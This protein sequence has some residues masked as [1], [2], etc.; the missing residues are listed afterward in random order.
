MKTKRNKL[1]NIFKTSSIL[2][3]ALLLFWNCENDDSSQV[4]EDLTNSYL[5]YVSLEKT[6]YNLI[7]FFSQGESIANK[8]NNTDLISWAKKNKY[9]F[10]PNNFIKTIDSIG[11]QAYTTSLYIN[12]TPDNVFYNLVIPKKVA[13]SFISSPFIIKYELAEGTKQNY[14]VS[15]QN[16]FV[17]TISVFSLANFKNPDIRA[18]GVVTD[19]NPCMKK[20]V[21]KN[22][23]SRGSSSSGSGGIW[24]T[25]SSEPVNNYGI[26]IGV[27]PFLFINTG[28]GGRRPAIIGVGVG[29][30]TFPPLGNVNRNKSASPDTI[31]C[32]DGTIVT[33]LLTDE[34]CPNKRVNGVCVGD[35]KIINH[36]TDKAKCVYDKLTESS[37]DFKNAI[38]KF[39]GDFPVSHLKLIGSTNLPS[40]VNARTSP[41]S[42]YLITI[43][44][45]SNKLNRPNLSI[46]RTII[47]ETIHAEMFRKILSILD[48]GGDLK[49]LTRS[50]WISKLSNGDYPGIFD[51]YSR[52]G[53]EMQHQQMAAHYIST[54]SSLLKEFQPGLSQNI[55]D[56]LAWTGLKN[57]TAWN[58]LSLTKR[59]SINKINEEFKKNGNKK[60]N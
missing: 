6:S 37:T 53:K 25:N 47:H 16:P 36:L 34:E 44:I 18:K 1:T 39:D 59:N 4:P 33:V 10:N 26:N 17:G 52:Y 45:N 13:H 2:L 58:A 55:Y 11:N 14:K 19:D 21:T 20:K 12:N 42:N 22:N 29:I 32:P 23:N 5:D 51:Y 40:N 41:P 54:I 24:S 15:S 49:G 31:R 50:Q 38:K 60:C 27:R 57:T 43:A 46:A 7:P 48:N 8:D 3:A 35:D 56:A 9:H 28:G 30:F